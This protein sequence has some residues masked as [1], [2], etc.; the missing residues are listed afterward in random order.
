MPST[1][2]LATE[3]RVPKVIFHCQLRVTTRNF[4]F[5]PIRKDHAR[6]VHNIKRSQNNLCI[7]AHSH[8]PFT[9]HINSLT[10]ST[11]HTHTPQPLTSAPTS[12]F[13]PPKK[14]K[15]VHNP[16]D[17]PPR[18]QL[19]THP[20]DPHLL[21]RLRDRPPAI[22]LLLKANNLHPRPRR[23]APRPRRYPFPGSS[24]RRRETSRW[25]FL[26]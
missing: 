20:P 17:N 14:R 10:L 11:D 3:T 2:V 18:L 1:T 16:L 15:N 8:F 22:H 23:P 7:H 19:R 13:H 12:T 6:T 24:A 9:N 25:S 21:R 26:S 4:P 5:R